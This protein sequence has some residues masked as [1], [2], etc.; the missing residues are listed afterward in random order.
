MLSRHRPPRDM[1]VMR[2][3]GVLVCRAGCVDGVFGDFSLAP[4]R[5]R[6]RVVPAVATQTSRATVG[7][8]GSGS[9]VLMPL[10]LTTLLL[11]VDFRTA[12]VF[13]GG[14]GMLPLRW[15]PQ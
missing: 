2:A 11:E 8:L 12:S 10:A 4:T 14:A 7:L 13:K 6:R 1:R 5:G 9:Q 3:A 15:A